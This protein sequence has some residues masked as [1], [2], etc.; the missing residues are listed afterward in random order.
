M[1][2]KYLEKEFTQKLIELCRQEK[3]TVQGALCAAM[4]LTVTHKIRM[5]SPRKIN[6]SCNSYIDLR[7]RLEPPIGNKDLSILASFITSMHQITPQISFWDLSRDVSKQIELGLKREDIFKPI[8]IFKKIIK[9]YIDNPDSSPLTVSVTNVGRV[10]I[11]N[12]YGDLELEEISFVLSN[13]I[14]S[15]IFTVAVTTFQEK[16]LLN[17]IASQPSVSQDT[18]EI[19]ANSVIDCLEEVCQK[20]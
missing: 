8:V 5:G 11:P 1:T 10:N 17:F 13:T 16:M 12:L 6:A 19:L 9:Y 2:Q 4:L 18:I 20:Y 7:R 3:T 15:K 14:F